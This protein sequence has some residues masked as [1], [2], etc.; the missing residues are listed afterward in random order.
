M[1]LRRALTVQLLAL[2]SVGLGTG[3]ARSDPANGSAPGSTATEAARAHFREGVRL[4]QDGR[5]SGA[6]SEFEAAFALK[7]GPGSLQNIALCQKALLRY[8]PAVDSLARLLGAYAGELSAEELDAAR[9]AKTELEALVRPVRVEVTPANAV[10]TVDALPL[11]E[12]AGATRRLNVGVHTF[13]AAARGYDRMTQTVTVSPG[14]TL[15]VVK[16][17][18]KPNAG[19]LEVT[20][21]DASHAIAIDGKPVAYGHYASVVT[22]RVPHLIQI[23]RPGEQA[24]ER[25]VTLL[26]GQTLGVSNASTR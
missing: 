7:P 1:R 16:L 6:L 19:F 14:T 9:R 22:P 20:A 25:R 2:A 11:A 17:A 13:S 24:F 10:I 3:A 26:P 15:L 12:P 5:Y 18:L 23:Y 4:Y 21:V 8:A